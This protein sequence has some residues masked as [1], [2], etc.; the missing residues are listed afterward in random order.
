M[1]KSKVLFLASIAFSYV[2]AED[3]KKLFKDAVDNCS[4]TQEPIL[5]HSIIDAA[6]KQA[7]LNAI[8]AKSVL[9]VYQSLGVM[10][11]KGSVK[12]D[13]VQKFLGNLIDDADRIEEI[14]ELCSKEKNTPEQT[15]IELFNCIARS[16][17]E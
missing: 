2:I 15:A 17:K 14:A 12:I 6:I 5:D 8:Y 1:D 9:C 7:N 11:D 3:P 10:D 16:V 4:K 13:Q